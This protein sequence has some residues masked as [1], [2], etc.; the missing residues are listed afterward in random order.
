MSDPSSTAASGEPVRIDVRRGSPTEDELAAL[1]AV[2]S[3]AYQRE[4]AAA[5]AENPAAA[6]AWTRTQRR[7]RAPMPRGMV[8]GRFSG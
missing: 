4:A 5:L 1:M 2:V 7:L 3:E 8:W 6:S